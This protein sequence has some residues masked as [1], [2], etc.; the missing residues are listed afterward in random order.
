[1]AGEAWRIIRYIRKHP[2]E[3]AV[4]TASVL[5]FGLLLYLLPASFTRIC[6][7]AGLTGLGYHAALTS[8]EHRIEHLPWPLSALVGR[9]GLLLPAAGTLMLYLVVVVASPLRIVLVGA[10]LVVCFYFWFVLPGAWY[11]KIQTTTESRPNSPDAALSVLIPAYN[12]AGSIGR[13]LDSI[14]SASY[15]GPKE[16]IVID[17]GSTDQTFETACTRAAAH[18]NVAI[19]QQ[20]NNGKHAALNTGLERATGEV[21]ITVDADSVVSEG[22]LSDIVVDLQRDPNLGAVAGSVKLLET[23]TLIARVQALE[24][25][26]GINTFRRAFG[27]LG[28]VNVIP[29]CLG[30]FRRTALDDIDGYDG[31]TLTEDFDITMQLL[32]EGWKVQSSAALVYT[33]A[34]Q[35]WSALYDQRLRWSRGNIETL[36]K[37]IGVLRGSNVDN[38]TGIVFP[39]QVI[40]LIAM[41]LAT[42]VVL[43]TIVIEALAGNVYYIAT[44]LL[45]FVFLQV[46]ASLF[47]LVVDD[48]DLSLLWYAP[49]AAT[50]YKFFIDGILLKALFEIIRRSDQVWTR[51]TDS[52]TAP[53]T[54]D[55]TERND[56]VTVTYELETNDD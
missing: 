50:A 3:A 8:I 9:G 13:C 28:V 1:M 14:I 18:E 2:N 19:L 40:S 53:D 6:I 37:H 55:V 30:C 20:E 44:M 42:V 43:A 11:Q 23:E 56:P 45:L 24:Y 51:E 16:I 32:R 36:V 27:M 48:T 39:Y 5:G 46:L 33:D 41:P 52:P 47:A 22:A 38:F 25:A 21:V 31:D 34:P 35:T 49:V 54:D 12:E 29:G 10:L 26:V 7:I 17:D 4:F 15:P